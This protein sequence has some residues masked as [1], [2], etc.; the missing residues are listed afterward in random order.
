MDNTQLIRDYLAVAVPGQLQ[1][2]RLRA[3]LA[4][5][6]VI[7][8]P[9]M[10][11]EGA[12][13]FVAALEATPSGGDMTSTVQDVVAGGDLVAARV[14]FRAGELAVQFSQWFWIADG[15]I[16]RIQVIYDPRPF[17]AAAGG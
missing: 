5:D 2:D 3:F 10:S 7:D 4:D 13:A 16:T 1:L 14:H 6:V 8:D 12:D 15:R 17:L 11:I 9:L